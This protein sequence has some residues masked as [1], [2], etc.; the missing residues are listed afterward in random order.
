MRPISPV[1]LLLITAL[2][3][4]FTA[5]V[6]FFSKVV[7]V[8]GDAAGNWLFMISTAVVLF[9]SVVF[10]IAVISLVL[11]LRL[12][13]SLFL[14][15]AAMCGYYTDRFGTIIDTGML[16]NVLQTDTREVREL[17]TPA[18]V[19]RLGLLGVLPTA[20][21]WWLP[22]ATTGLLRD[23]VHQAGISLLSLLLV[24]ATVFAL[25]DY[26]ASFF[27]ER[28]TLRMYAN[29]LTALYSGIRLTGAKLASGSVV[30]FRTIA[31]D[32]RIADT[33]AEHELV[34]LV[35]GETARHDR[36]SLNGYERKTNPELEREKRLVSYT[37]ITSCGT[38][39]TVSLPCLFALQGRE[40]FDLDDARTQ[41]NLLDVLQRVGVSVLWR[42]NN[43]SSKGV[44]DRVR[45][46][47]FR[48]AEVNPVCDIECRDVGMLDGLPEYIDSQPGDILI[49]LH[50]MGNHGPAYY[51]RYPPAFERFHPTCQSAD[52]SR[53][54][55]E[56]ISNA[57]DNAILYTDYF[58][59]QV[60]GLLKTY[61]PKY[62]TAMIYV[63]DHG[64]SLG[65]HGLYLHGAPFLLAPDEQIRV[66]VI[67]WLGES[68]DIEL[69]AA[70][71]V[72]HRSNSHDAVSASLLAAFEVETSA[73]PASAPLLWERSR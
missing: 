46:E 21:L 66:P 10:S 38:S 30:E 12:T 2:F 61:T 34:I 15:I 23:R 17:V 72:Q 58:L 71:R 56:E 4:T 45:F 53:C 70:R 31:E 68:A 8:Y 3:L 42:D 19:L 43:S 54:S 32:A 22:L 25:G 27:R 33:E 41:E 55:T 47:D 49:V 14:V 57:Y 28:K 13:L 18:L 35:I 73:I 11:P 67:L 40:D 48:S 69:E 65:E 36:F 64:E 51:K 24:I 1:L 60:I 62:E 6:T 29:P 16:E 9:S 39:T 44:A 37:N 52:L 7:E 5:N 59:A 63:S 26:Y 20:V 50:Q